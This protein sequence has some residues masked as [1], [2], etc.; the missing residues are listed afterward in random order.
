MPTYERGPAAGN[1]LLT[2]LTERFTCKRYDPDRKV[3]PGD[4]ETI[5]E[6]ARLAASSFGLEPWQLLVVENPQIEQGMLERAWGMKKNAARNV[7]I[8]AR[9]HLTASDPYLPELLTTVKKLSEAEAK[10]RLEVIDNFQ[11]HDFH[12][13][14]PEAQFA[15]TRRQSFIA[16]ANMLTAAAMLKV[17]ATPVEGF[18]EEAMNQFFC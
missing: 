13:T 3:A 17:D 1:L 14:T 7:V 15:W 12:L 11:A 4:F 2:A 5:L 9:K 6:A 10:A 16:L 8:L 18:D